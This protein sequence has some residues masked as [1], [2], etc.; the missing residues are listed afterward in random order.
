MAGLPHPG[1]LS[2]LTE[3]CYSKHVRPSEKKRRRLGWCWSR[4]RCYLK[5]SDGGEIV[6]IA[7]RITMAVAE[8]IPPLDALRSIEPQFFADYCKFSGEV[9][10]FLSD[11][12]SRAFATDPNDLRRRYHLL[13]IISL[14]YAAYEDAAAMIMSFLDYRSGAAAIPLERLMEYAPG[15]AVLDKVLT[16]N[17]ISTADDL[18]N[19]LDLETWI[20]TDW[21]VWFPQLDLRKALKLVCQFLVSDCRSNQ[22]RL[23]VAA[24]NKIKHGLLVVPSA[25]V[26]SKSMPDVPAT[27]IANRDTAT[28]A[29]SPFVLYAFEMD[30][31]KIVERERL[32]HF[33]QKSLRILSALYLSHTYPATVKRLW[34][35][36][37]Q[38]LFASTDF[39]DVQHFIGEITAKK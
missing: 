3:A 24:Y 2:R 19:R 25:R 26:Y 14:E 17:S 22:K 7:R 30:D 36:N 23:G 37:A 15:E 5:V 4:Q 32:V 21:P 9:R 29:A 1:G 16:A 34:G 38:Q 27:I 12:L 13:S 18:Y 39:R 31:S 33:V 6:S 8:T 20:P 35:G 11:T 10:E 28:Q